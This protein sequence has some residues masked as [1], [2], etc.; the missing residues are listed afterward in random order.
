MV[1]ERLCETDTIPLMLLETSIRRRFICWM[2]TNSVV[3]VSPGAS[4][5]SHTNFTRIVHKSPDGPEP[6][7]DYPSTNILME[8]FPILPAEGAPELF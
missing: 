8:E 2:R 7:F 1:V 4:D 3:D 5:S 6:C